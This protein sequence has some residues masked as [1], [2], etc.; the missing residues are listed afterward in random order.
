MAPSQFLITVPVKG[1]A[2]EWRW[3]HYTLQGA[4]LSYP[5]RDPKGLQQ[6]LQVEQ[7]MRS[8][9]QWHQADV[10]IKGDIVPTKVLHVFQKL[11]DDVIGI[12]HLSGELIRKSPRAMSGISPFAPCGCYLKLTPVNGDNHV[13]FTYVQPS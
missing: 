12:C 7:F 11:V 3:R 6:W 4:R 9:W 8:L 10:N 1:L 2:R 5:L 13:L